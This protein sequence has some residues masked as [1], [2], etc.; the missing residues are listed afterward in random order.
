MAQLLFMDSFATSFKPIFCIFEFTWD[1]KL[2][3]SYTNPATNLVFF[4][5]TR[6]TWCVSP[7]F[8]CAYHDRKTCADLTC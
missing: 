8:Q 6:K 2:Y 7:M 1:F 4:G 3:V 5:K